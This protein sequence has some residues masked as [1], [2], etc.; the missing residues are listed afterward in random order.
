ML[1]LR[2]SSSSKCA[3]AAI[4]SKLNSADT[5]RPRSLYLRLFSAS[6]AAGWGNLVNTDKLKKNLN[7][8]LVFSRGKSYCTFRTT[9]PVMAGEELLADYGSSFKGHRRTPTALDSSPHACV[10]ATPTGAATAREP[11]QGAGSGP[12]PSN[13]AGLH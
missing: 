12:S 10:V 11:R 7:C 3:R 5:L 13:E 1:C 9:R 8:R 6:R 4:K 2:A